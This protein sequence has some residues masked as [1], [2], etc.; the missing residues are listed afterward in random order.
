MTP[1]GTVIEF[2][3]VRQ[4]NEPPIKLNLNKND[5]KTAI[6]FSKHV[7]QKLSQLE[8]NILGAN[9]QIHNNTIPAY[10]QYIDDSHIT[11]PDQQEHILKHGKYALILSKASQYIIN[12]KCL[13]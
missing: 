1:I 6:E 10:G 13:S 8:T 11:T 3:E 7:I 4:Q 12:S 9:I 2:N 5:I